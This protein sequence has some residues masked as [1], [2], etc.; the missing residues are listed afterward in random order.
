MTAMAAEK[1]IT[2]EASV[3]VVDGAGGGVDAMEIRGKKA[4]VVGLARTGL[5]VSRFLATR[6]ASVTA[7]DLRSIEELPGVAE[8]DGLGVM[9]LTGSHPGVEALDADLIVLSPGVPSDLPIIQE[10]RA[11]GVSV[12]G[13]LEL[14]SR[15]ID[16]P[17]VAVAGTNG[18]TTTTA[19][20]GEILTR[21][22]RDVFVGGNIGTPAI[23]YAISGRKAELCV[24]EV[25]SFQLE[26][27]QSFCPHIGV[28][29]NI[30]EDH[31]DRYDGFDGYA[32]TKM[33]LFENQTAEDFAVVN[34]ADS[35]I[36]AR[37]G[38]GKAG[39]RAIGFNV[40]VGPGE[41]V[42]LSGGDVV[43]SIGGAREVY[44]AEGFALR[45]LHNT[46]NIMAAVAAARILGVPAG[47]IRETLSAF[48][49]LCHRMEL[50]R[51]LDCVRYINDSKGTNIGALAMALKGMTAPVVLIAGGVDKGGDYLA[52]EAVMREKVKLLVLIGE[53]RE[54]IF[55]ALGHTTRTVM[56][57][58]LEEAVR[59]AHAGAVEGD[60][61]LLS[62]ACSSFDMFAG[63]AERGERF[64]A[65]V[66]EL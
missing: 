32:A 54:K 19:L 51:E 38:S 39:G 53:A 52:L 2:H 9:L 7:T 57:Q 4:L 3:T 63:Y 23:E 28:L 49:G 21:A 46:E 1:G 31:L 40:P 34:M 64:A 47:V 50:V 56:V 33:R 13:E 25:S 5:A 14:A 42:Y 22:G 65:L 12:M 48:E 44:S 43:S 16:C 11:R 30:T 17:I 37:F 35:E 29:L 58:G 8:L 62:P 41:G 55:R 26:T 24:L 10:A 27:I 36:A 66:E 61:V 45:G 15:F 60:T 18:K 59:V 20:L 6:G